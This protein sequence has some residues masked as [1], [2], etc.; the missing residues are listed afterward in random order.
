[1]MFFFHR[2]AILKD[3]PSF[4]TRRSSDL[5]DGAKLGLNNRQ[6]PHARGGG[7]DQFGPITATARDREC[8]ICLERLEQ[9]NFLR[10]ARGEEDRCAHGVSPPNWRTSSTD[11]ALDFACSTSLRS[12][13]GISTVTALLPA[14]ASGPVSSLTPLTCC[15]CARKRC[16]S[17]SVAL[18][19][20]DTI[21]TDMTT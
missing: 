18:R 8:P 10:P 13:S 6:L 12:S 1:M 7:R 20:V 11:P 19:V 9:F 16:S 21:Q 5:I 17:R 14:S 2:T 15:P 4:P 3:L